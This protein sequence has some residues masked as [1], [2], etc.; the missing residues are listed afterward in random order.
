VVRGTSAE[1]R[2]VTTGL[3]YGP[4]TEVIQGLSAG[5]LVATSRVE[6]L[7]DGAPVRVGAE[8]AQTQAAKK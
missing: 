4:V 6:T 7:S 8:A 1:Q 3:T 2:M 5:E